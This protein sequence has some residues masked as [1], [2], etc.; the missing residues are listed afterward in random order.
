MPADRF[1]HQRAGHSVKVNLLNDLE[2]RVWTQYLLS[3]NDFGV[4]R[5]DAL[6]LQNDNSH[7]SRR[8]A[9]T[10]MRCLEAVKGR[11]L[12]QTFEHQGRIY[13]YQT[14]WQDWQKVRWPGKTLLPKPPAEG[15]TPATLHLFSVFPG[16]RG[17]PRLT[18]EEL[19]KNYVSTSE[20]LPE[21]FSGSSATRVMANG[22]RPMANGFKEKKGQP[23][24]DEWFRALS[25]DYPQ[26]RVTSGYAT[27]TA[28]MDAL[29]GY[30]D[31][32]WGGWQVMRDN[33]ENQKRG[34]QWRVKRMI[35]KLQNWLRDGAWLQQHEEA[36]PDTL[37][38]E[39][40]SRTLASAAAFIKA[41]AK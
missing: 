31:G 8:S 25:D 32:P 13:C 2:Y 9:K 6:P 37:V 17:V 29:N 27:Q 38:S 35:P 3:A 40:T 16:G 19:A 18:D 26:E 22:Y 15:M 34:Y 23:P 30:Q 1:L 41:G 5:F 20:V 12:I 33:L 21:N 24:F 36:P 39:K 4:M 14:D 28:F 11:G 10:V 7:L